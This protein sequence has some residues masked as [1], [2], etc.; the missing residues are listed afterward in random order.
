MKTYASIV[1][2]TEQFR[3]TACFEFKEVNLMDAEEEMLNTLLLKKL[4]RQKASQF[5]YLRKHNISPTLCLS[6]DG[7]VKYH[8]I[9]SFLEI[10]N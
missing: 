8:E 7:M 2:I 3:F 10:S 6:K 9:I 5:K 1:S 4:L